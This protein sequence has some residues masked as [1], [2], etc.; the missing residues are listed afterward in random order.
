MRESHVLSGIE[1]TGNLDELYFNE[2]SPGKSES[3]VH[4]QLQA[5]TGH[6][7]SREKPRQQLDHSISLMSYGLR[8]EGIGVRSF[9][10]SRSNPQRPSTTPVKNKHLQQPGQPA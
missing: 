7:A 8:T 6:G 4:L 3:Q 1:D 5:I 10:T 2:Y 9:G